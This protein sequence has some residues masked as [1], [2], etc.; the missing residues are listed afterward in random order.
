M[1]S[2]P[3][4]LAQERHRSGMLAEA[5][6]AYASFLDANPQRGDV[7]HLRALAEHQ[8]GQVDASWQ[9]VNR[10]LDASGEQPATVLLAGMLLRDRGDLEG[11][12]L[13][14]LS[15]IVL[16]LAPTKRAPAAAPSPSTSAPGWPQ[17]RARKS[18]RATGSATVWSEVR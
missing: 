17:N 10:A 14:V 3:L 5:I 6:A 12:V 9:S 2:D 1:S 15:A 7:W 16:S 11:L 18:S 13:G 8:S 4:Q